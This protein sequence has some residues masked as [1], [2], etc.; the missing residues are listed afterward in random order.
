VRGL[1]VQDGVCF[2]FCDT[3]FLG[4]SVPYFPYRID[5]RKAADPARSAARNLGSSPE[6]RDIS[7]CDSTNVATTPAGTDDIAFVRIARFLI[8]RKSRLVR[9]SL[10]LSLSPRRLSDSQPAWLVAANYN[11]ES[12][13]PHLCV[14]LIN[15][16]G[17][18]LP[19]YTIFL[20]RTYVTRR[21]SNRLN[22]ES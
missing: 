11:R 20:L 21:Q 18:T 9:A 13:S 5:F 10:I 16:Y 22:P 2:F 17:R 4:N 8:A 7:F 1:S 6:P 14:T 3:A 15:R 12:A 19:L